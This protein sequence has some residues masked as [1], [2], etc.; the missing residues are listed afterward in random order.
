MIRYKASKG[1]KILFVGINPH[2][3]SFRRGVP[4]SNNKTFW[5]L[6][7]RSG[8][9]EEDAGS[10]RDDRKLKA[11]YERRFERR[12]KLGFVNIIN[13]PTP[14]VTSLKKGEEERG[15]KRILSLIARYEPRVV[16]FIGK[17]TYQKFTGSAD[18]GFGWQGS[19]FRSKC[20]VMHFPIRGPARVRV[21]ELR[22]AASAAG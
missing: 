5:Y 7:A 18:F 16:C 1:L 9:I 15:R 21:R 10:L 14:D 2:P 4:F 19:I 6:L 22:E 20:Y 17:V 12:W 11:F 8:L 13:R 3:G